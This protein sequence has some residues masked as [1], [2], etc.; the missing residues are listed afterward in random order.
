MTDEEERQLQEALALS[1][2]QQ[3]Q[4]QQQA[5]LRWLQSLSPRRASTQAWLMNCSPPGCR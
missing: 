4:Q 5:V 3:Q 2:Q 1:L